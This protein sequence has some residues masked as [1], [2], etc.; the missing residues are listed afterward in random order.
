M[1]HISLP[2]TIP[3]MV[4]ENTVFFPESILPLYIFESRYR[5]MLNSV[6]LGDRFFTVIPNLPDQGSPYE[7]AHEETI[8]VGCL[9]ACQTH[10]DGSSTVL[11][12]GICRAV[13][14]DYLTENPY[15]IL[16]INPC[17]DHADPTHLSKLRNQALSL[18]EEIHRNS[19]LISTE[20]LN[21]LK[22]IGQ[23]Q[24]FL[25]HVAASIIENQ[26]EKQLILKCNDPVK[27]YANL[28]DRL[29]INLDRIQLLNQ[30]LGNFD[31]DAIER[32]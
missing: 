25:D 9:R 6:I 15:P 5:L 17:R 18:L 27:Q 24:L 7:P 2:E 21:H 22:K 13:V 20:M 31:Q 26:M 14:A 1:G 32:N 10:R 29:R 16:K 30:V 28:M 19:D 23:P 4:I 12:E 11:L 8:T 3:A